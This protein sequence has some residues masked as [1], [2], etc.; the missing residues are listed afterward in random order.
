[1]AALQSYV[2][3]Y[4]SGELAVVT[5]LLSA[6]FAPAA[7]KNSTVT[8]RADLIVRS[9]K[10]TG[11]LAL[12]S[13]VNQSDRK[14]S[15][16]LQS[17]VTEE[18]FK[19]NLETLAEPP[20]SVVAQ[21]ME[22]ADPPH[23]ANARAMTNSAIN[24]EVG[25]FATGLHR[26]STFRG[27]IVIAYATGPLFVWNASPE[28]GAPAPSV[29]SMASVGKMFTSVAIAQLEQEGR[30]SLSDPIGKFLP[31]YPNRDASENVTVGH[32][33]THSS[34]IAEYMDNSAYQ[35]AKAAAGGRLARTSEYL[36]FFAAA[37]LQFRPGQKRSYSNSGYVVLGTLIE[38]LTGK[39][40]P[41]H[42][43]TRILI[44]SGMSETAFDSIRPAGGEMSTGRDLVKF[45]QALIQGKLLSPAQTR[46]VL[47]S[48]QV[49]GESN[50]YGL[51][52][53]VEGGVHVAGHGGGAPGVGARL[54]LFPARGDVAAV[55]V[56]GDDAAARRLA[57]KIRR[58]M[59][60]AGTNP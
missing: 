26:H 27:Q 28:Q 56:E 6:R 19:L 47:S 42:V 51:E 5:Q 41:Q 30:V 44:P 15:A 10:F 3:A 24:S 59:V 35:S 48:S 32:L 25:R 7:L 21:S 34:G 20:Y 2:A 39:S 31:D 55:L 45:G 54:D 16:L 37:P 50:S 22:F 46:Q 9:R 57:D 14:V 60:R 52:T 23:Q 29:F 18:W 49:A 1:M 11:P 8:Q 12:R 43:S 17:T 53:T 38:R 4:N 13:V 33:L 36:P 40:F 58:V